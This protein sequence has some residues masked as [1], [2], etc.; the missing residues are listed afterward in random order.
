MAS[1][2]VAVSSID[3]A[4]F[5]KKIP[6]AQRPAFNALKN[7]QDAYVRRISALPENLPKID[8]ASYKTKI[9]VPG[10]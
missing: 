6:A 1:R 2:R 3:W 4:E 7:K 5:A 10:K 9:Q 8:F